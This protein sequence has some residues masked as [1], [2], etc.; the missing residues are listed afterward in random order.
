[1]GNFFSLGSRVCIGIG[2][3]NPAV[4]APHRLSLSLVTYPPLAVTPQVSTNLGPVARLDCGEGQMRAQACL[5][6][7]RAGSFCFQS[8]LHHDVQE[9]IVGKNSRS[10]KHP[11]PHLLT[12]GRLFLPREQGLH[13]NTKP[14]SFGTTQTITLFSHVSTSCS[15]ASS[16]NE[17]RSSCKT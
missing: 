8:R 3:L 4:L 7:G 14:C 10:N 6:N 15:H 2:I 1:M 16:L 12:N 11:T 5:A 9:A 13:W 17:P